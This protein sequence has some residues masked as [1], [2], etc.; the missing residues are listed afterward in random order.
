[1][2]SRRIACRFA[3]R[4]MKVTGSPASA[5]FAPTKQPIA[6]ALA[7]Q[8]GIKLS[9]LVREPFIVRETGS[10]TWQSMA[11]GLG[12]HTAPLN[13]AMQIKS[14]ET[15]KQAVIAG[16]GISFLSA[17]TVSRELRDGSLTVL[18]VQDFPKML[19]WYV[20]SRRSKL[21]PPVAQ[22]F[23]QF[24]LNDGA[25]LIAEYVRLTPPAPPVKP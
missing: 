14:T 1:M 11:D 13:I 8:R 17:H 21:L 12:R 3:P 7:G 20:V 24:L 6:P 25:D 23:R 4:A 2:P 9:R 22:A 18:D 15:I 5:S 10:D 16:M 19:H